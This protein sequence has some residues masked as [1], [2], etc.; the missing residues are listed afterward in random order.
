[1]T[2]QAQTGP[3]L[4]GVKR[5]PLK[6][7]FTGH[8]CYMGEESTPINISGHRWPQKVKKHPNIPWAQMVRL[9]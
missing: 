5:S 2:F 6:N 7:P 1:M 3:K 4:L 9:K 8:P